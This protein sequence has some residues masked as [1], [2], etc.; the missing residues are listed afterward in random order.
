MPTTKPSAN[1]TEF[2]HLVFTMD[3]IGVHAISTKLSWGHYVGIVSA[4]YSTSDFMSSKCY[5]KHVY[6][7]PI[8]KVF[9][10]SVALIYTLTYSQSSSMVKPF[11][12]MICNWWARWCRS[13]E[14]GMDVA[15]V[16]ILH[17]LF[18]REEHH[19]RWS[20]V[21]NCNL[22]EVIDCDLKWSNF[23]QRIILWCDHCYD[24]Q[25]LINLS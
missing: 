5:S 21:T 16:I 7:W 20:H 3:W 23:Q 25:S 13:D 6:M 22:T 15:Q 19:Q 18:L 4:I 10:I 17:H 8:F 24:H 9:S 14:Y 1:S 12:E 2:R 11:D